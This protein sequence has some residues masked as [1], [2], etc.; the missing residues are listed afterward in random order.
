MKLCLLLLFLAGGITLRSQNLVPNGS[1]EDYSRLPC[2]LN[3]FLI[4]DL[5]KNWLQP[6]SATTDYWNTL[7]NTDC[8]L[9]P[10]NIALSP[11]TGQGMVGI[12]T[13]VIQ[14]GARR[15]YKEYVEV[16]LL[17]KLKKG[18]LYNVEF[19]AQNRIKN[20]VQS[21]I[22]ASNNLGA[23]FSDSLILHPY[24]GN[25]PDHLL[26]KASIKEDEIVY[27]SWQ[28]IGGCFPATS[29]SHYL[30]IGNFDSIDST[31]L[32]QLTFGE[33]AAQ[34]YYFLDD[35]SVEELPYD[36]SALS[37]RVALCSDQAFIALNAF[38]DG[39]TDYQW[40]DGSKGPSFKVSAK[41][42]RDYTVDISFSECTYSHTFHVN[43]VP[44]LEL[45]ADTT[46]CEGEELTLK[47][48]HPINE[49]LWSDGSSDNVKTISAP[50]YFAVTVPSDGCIIQDSIDV[51]FLDCPGFAPNIITPNED[52]YN[53]YFV[54]ENIDNRSWSLKVF[55]KWGQE[56]Y[57]SLDYKNNW[58]G[59]DLSG[60]VYYY[61]L[62]CSALKKE[63]KG[64]V[65]L[66]R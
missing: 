52:G 46:L 21:D 1:F 25:S 54:F 57:F 30:S 34:A 33:D 40:E 53:E 60:G 47:P 32:E 37:Q 55:N 38:V 28:K 2:G 44:D 64:W 7:S 11:R 61:K 31:R 16:E 66:F 39:A 5:L 50:G 27:S 24:N 10:A 45:G 59:Q 14:G 26:L 4:Q 48:Q 9:N 3:E 65:H 62:S 51:A 15:E 42:N 29:T 20:I 58:N 35:V 17:S 22:L 36:V 18:N 13:A 12:I 8:F 43:Y 41:T 23:A 63:V 6:T 49:F 19:Y 56:V